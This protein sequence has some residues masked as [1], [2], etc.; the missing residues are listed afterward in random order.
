MRRKIGPGQWEEL[1]PGVANTYT[2]S[3]SASVVAATAR[4]IGQMEPSGV[5][6]AM[7]FPRSTGDVHRLGIKR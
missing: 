7:P 5:S 4:P 2:G 3:R 6:P 1:G